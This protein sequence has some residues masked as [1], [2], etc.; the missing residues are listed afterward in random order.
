MAVCLFQAGLVHVLVRVLG[1][2]GVGVGVFVADVVVLVGGV[3]M[4]VRLIAVLVLVLVGVRRVMGVLLGHGVLLSVRNLLRF[5]RIHGLQPTLGAVMTGNPG[6]RVLG[7]E[8]GVG[9]ELAHVIVF[10]AVEN[11]GSVA[12]GAYQA[13]HP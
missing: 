9:D 3:R 11:G 7:V 1:P 6:T 8:D 13:C 4:G 12:A 2:V 10:Q 5:G